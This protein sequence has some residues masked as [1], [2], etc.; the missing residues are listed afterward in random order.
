MDEIYGQS[1]YNFANV[2]REILNHH[3]VTVAADRFS[4]D[5]SKRL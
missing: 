1:E 3:T 2:I 4:G 5:L